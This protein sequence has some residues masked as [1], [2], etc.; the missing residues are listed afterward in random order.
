ML[1]WLIKWYLKRKIEYVRRLS[2]ICWD[3]RADNNFGGKSE[4]YWLGFSEGLL[5]ASKLYGFEQFNNGSVDKDL[6][7]K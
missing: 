4:D 5:A 2:E 7:G 1:L 6:K 3:E